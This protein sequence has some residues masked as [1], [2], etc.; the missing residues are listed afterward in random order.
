MVRTSAATDVDPDAQASEREAGK[1]AL[2]SMEEELKRSE[3]R[4]AQ[5]EQ[6]REELRHAR[7]EFSK[8]LTRERRL[9]QDESLLLQSR[10][11]AL[12]S[13]NNELKTGESDNNELKSG[14][15]VSSI[16]SKMVRC[17]CRVCEVW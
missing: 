2:N 3:A 16:S 12:E 14:I 17:L 6:E 8:I 5:V 13:D 1:Q 15:F 11:E 7:E 4:V 9:H 10:F